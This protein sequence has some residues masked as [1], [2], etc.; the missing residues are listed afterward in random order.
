M[1]LVWVQ[2]M[3]SKGRV[4]ACGRCGQCVGGLVEQLCAAAG[5][6]KDDDH[7]TTLPPVPAAPGVGPAVPAQPVQCSLGCGGWYCSATC[8]EDD[9]ASGVHL[10]LCVG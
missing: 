6:D 7:R 2:G 1:S 3:E 10:A 4:M 5:I 9:Q 8:A